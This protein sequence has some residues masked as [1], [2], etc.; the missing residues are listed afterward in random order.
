MTNTNRTQRARYT[1]KV[2]TDVRNRLRKE[3]SAAYVQEV[4]RIDED[5][6]IRFKRGT[7]FDIKVAVGDV[8]YEM[9]WPSTASSLLIG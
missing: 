2:L 7:P 5:V 3:G 4:V 9:R 6:A 1:K 8:M